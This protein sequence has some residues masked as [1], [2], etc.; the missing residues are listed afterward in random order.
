MIDVIIP[1]IR[2]WEKLEMT[3]KSLHANSV[4]PLCVHITSYGK[5]Y[6]QAVNHAYENSKQPIL[7]AG[8]DD[9]KFY[10]GW[11][12]NMMRVFNGSEKIMVVGTND[13]HHPATIKGHGATHYGFRRTYI[14]RFTG[15]IDRSYPVLFDY[16]HNY[17]D[18]EFVAVAKARG[19]YGHAI[20]SV[21]EH[22]HPCWGMAP[23]DAGYDK[24]RN[25]CKDD[26]VVFNQRCCQWKTPDI[27]IRGE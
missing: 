18:A 3:L 15:T 27:I 14:E 23:L 26:G 12:V 16:K 5:S 2:P 17:T 25:T 1:T 24:S 20:D 10:R 9:L 13:L 19:V 6:A 4:I 7:F 8:A 21:V 22:L 11:D